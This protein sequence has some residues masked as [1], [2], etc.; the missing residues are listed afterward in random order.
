MNQH[1]IIGNLVHDPETGTTEGGVN[2]CRFKVAVR[3]KYK[4]KD[5]QPDADFIRV[6]A[7]RGLG[8][9]CAKYLKKGRKVCVVGVPQAGAWIGQ[10]G[11]AKGQIEL[12]ADDV[13][14]LSGGS[15]GGNSAPT[16]EDAPPAPGGSQDAP[17]DPQSGMTVVEDPEEI[18]F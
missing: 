17:V 10:D 2:W 18:P 4:P 6:T 15:G 5:G 9:T 13:E 11:K 14:F 1:M 3:K 16:D 7:W 12:I 8:D